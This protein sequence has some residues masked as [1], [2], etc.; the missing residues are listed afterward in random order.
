MIHSLIL[1]SIEANI[2][3][4]FCILLKIKDGDKDSLQ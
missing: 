3:K 4:A 1:S 2:H